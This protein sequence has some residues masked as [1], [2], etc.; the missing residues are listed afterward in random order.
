MTE[1]NVSNNNERVYTQT[2]M[3]NIIRSVIERMEDERETERSSEKPI[4]LEIITELEGI[5]SHQLQENFRRFKKD[6]RK[7]QS[8]EWLLPKKINKSVLPYIKKHHTETTSIITTIQKCTEHTRF[9]ARVAMEIF[10]ELQGLLQA[11]DQQ[12]ARRILEGVIETSKRL[13]IFGLTTS[14]NQERETKTFADK[15][16]NLPISIKHLETTEEDGKTKNAY[17]EEFLT[18]YHQARFEQRLLQQN[19][20]SNRGRGNGDFQRG[21][22]R[23]NRGRGSR[24]SFFG[25][26]HPNKW[27]NNNSYQSQDQ[28]NNNASQQ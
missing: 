8:T 15:A 21:R 1:P 22:G 14:K 13:A 10:E 16:L 18:N 27:G 9:Q 4:P 3:E 20:Q 5:S 17:S 11:S 12:Q 19:S 23:G 25:S 6:T 24:G 7:Y 26:G 28:P 2:E